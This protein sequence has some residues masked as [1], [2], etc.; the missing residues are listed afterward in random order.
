[1]LLGPHSP[2]ANYS[3]TATVETQTA[4]PELIQRWRRGIRQRCTH[5]G[6][7]RHIQRRDA[8]GD[9]NTV[10]ATGCTSWYLGQDGNPELWPWNPADC[11]H[12]WATRIDDHDLRIQPH[13]SHK[14]MRSSAASDREPRTCCAG[15]RG[16]TPDP[17][18]CKRIR[19][20]AACA[21]DPSRGR[22]RDEPLCSPRLQCS[23]ES[24]RLGLGRPAHVVGDHHAVSNPLHGWRSW[25]TPFA[26][27]PGTSLARASTRCSRRC[28]N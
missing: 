4:T 21:C 22:R 28:Q 5:R 23:K 25:V 7:H 17:L 15:P 26:I 10:W 9:A 1:M 20:S 8:G 11:A 6:R 18:L 3:L 27:H 2:I 19:G 12:D 24:H 14:D 16:R 13:P